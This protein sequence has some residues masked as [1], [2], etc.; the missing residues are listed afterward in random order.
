MKRRIFGRVTFPVVI[1]TAQYAVSVEAQD[2]AGNWHI[3]GI[4]EAANRPDAAGTDF[5]TA[6]VQ[7]VSFSQTHATVDDGA[8]DLGP[9]LVVP[10]KIR[11]RAVTN[12]GAQAALAGC[13]IWLSFAGG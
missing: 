10:G 11:I 3:W 12:T 8:G 1:A 13:A 2:S 9:G 4:F 7:M 5:D 6:G